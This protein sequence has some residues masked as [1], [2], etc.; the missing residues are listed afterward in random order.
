MSSSTV[1]G[2]PEPGGGPACRFQERSVDLDPGP[3]P[4]KK[5][6]AGD[7]NGHGS[8]NIGFIPGS[9]ESVRSTPPCVPCAGL[10]QP[11]C[12]ASVCCLLTC[13]LYRVCGRCVRVPC[14]VAEGDTGEPA[15]PHLRPERPVLQEPKSLLTG[16]FRYPDVQVAGRRV[17]L[18]PARTGSPKRVSS[19]TAP[20][21][22]PVSRASV[23]SLDELSDG[24]SEDGMDI[25]SL[26]TKK[27]LELY[28][29]H[30]IEQLARCTSDS[31]FLS[32][33]SHISQLIGDIQREHD[34]REEDAECR[35]VHGIIRLSTRKGAGSRRD[36]TLPDSGNDT[37]VETT[38]SFHSNHDVR[39]S[40]QTSS[41]RVARDMR[42]SSYSAPWPSP[43]ASDSET[44][45][46]GT[47]LLRP[48][49]PL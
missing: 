48:L 37:M 41:D 2:P 28:T 29:Q 14:L 7:A 5:S 8:E 13:G 22:P 3:W 33:T 35:L 12:Q 15:E 46:S 23:Y 21:K 44:A 20:E 19:R 16:S 42:A 17:P 24:G 18:Q 40:E 32:R 43:P 1:G 31:V 47:P 6:V 39:I 26:I 45:S 30:Q 34:L 27:L 11:G 10:G 36:E 49:G 25:D 4:P 38:Y 9:V